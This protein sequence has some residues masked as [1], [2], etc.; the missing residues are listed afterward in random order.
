MANL[1]F[2][3]FLLVPSALATAQLWSADPVDFIAAHRSMGFWRKVGTACCVIIGL[4]LFWV[5]DVYL[6]LIVMPV[7]LF[8][9]VV[10]V[11]QRP[12]HRAS[13][14]R[15][16]QVAAKAAEVV[17]VRS[18]AREDARFKYQTEQV[19]EEA[20]LEARRHREDGD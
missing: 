8:G 13:Y 17:T 7:A 4:A 20:R 3:V 19:I 9:I 15:R 12:V 10:Y 18:D 14:D 6:V 2:V 1:V 11:A 5:N 16:G